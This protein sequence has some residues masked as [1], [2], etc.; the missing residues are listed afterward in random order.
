[1]LAAGGLFLLGSGLTAAGMLWSG[2]Y[3]IGIGVLIVAV[4]GIVVRA[5]DLARILLTRR[6]PP[7][8]W[9]GHLLPRGHGRG[10]R[11]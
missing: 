4:I 8:D 2:L 9:D 1:M 10:E 11:P 3:D 7:A 6:R 5:G